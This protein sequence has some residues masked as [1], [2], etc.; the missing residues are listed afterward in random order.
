MNRVCRCFKRLF[1]APMPRWGIG[2][3]VALMTLRPGVALAHDGPPP[4]PE[5]ILQ[6]WSWEPSVLLGLALA[7]WL[8]ARGVRLLWRRAG[9]G[10]GIR[11]GQ[12]V[13]FAGGLFAIFVALISPLDGLG[14][15]L[16]AGHM[17]QHLILTEVAAPLLTLGAPLLPVLWALPPV[18]R[19]GVGHWWRQA[20]GLRSTWRSLTHPLVVWGL[21]AITLWLWHIPTLYQATL[22]SEWAHIAQHSSFLG[23]GLLFWWALLHPGGH[24]GLN[25]GAGILLVFTTMLHS[26]LLGVLMTFSTTAW[27]PVYTPAVAAWGLTPVEDQQMGGLIMWIV[28]GAIYMVAAVSL[29]GVWLNTLEHRMRRRESQPLR[30]ATGVR[31]QPGAPRAQEKQ[32]RGNG[33]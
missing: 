21:F 1:A 8:Y 26:G 27:Y 24:R 4:T 29:C 17:A 12:V 32:T 10:R 13:A 28:G 2:V 14:A 23:T 19:R 5:N 6:T 22:R 9:V 3:L 16:F 11:I 15:A 18:W 7:A 30:G 20:R 31:L 33:A 25:Y